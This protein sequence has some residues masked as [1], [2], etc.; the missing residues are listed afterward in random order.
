MANDAGVPMT[1]TDQSLRQGYGVQRS[2][3][4]AA[5]VLVLVVAFGSL[6]L[7]ALF[8]V[9]LHEARSGAIIPVS[10]GTSRKLFALLVG[11]LFLPMILSRSHPELIRQA[12]QLIC[13]NQ[14][15]AG[16]TKMVVECAGRSNPVASLHEF[17]SSVLGFSAF[18]I[19]L[20]SKDKM[21]GWVDDVIASDRKVTSLM[22]YAPIAF[23]AYLLVTS[24]FDI[25]W[26][27]KGFSDIIPVAGI[28]AFFCAY[29][30][31]LLYCSRRFAPKDA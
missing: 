28:G 20:F 9:M 26:G 11:G 6:G 2:L 1:Q 27:R 10:D 17:L 31:S 4:Y 16:L 13:E 22:I 7:A 14:L 30:A 24:Q 12:S 19:A 5:C 18:A 8:P 15:Y 23:G 3:I 21:D 25:V 29:I